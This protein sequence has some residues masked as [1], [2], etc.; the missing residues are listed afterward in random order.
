MND[1]DLLDDQIC[2]DGDAHDRLSRVHGPGELHATLLALLLPAGSRRALQAWREETGSAAPLDAL[3]EDVRNLSGAA[4]LPW[5]DRLLARM[6][7]QPIEARQRLLQSTRRVIGARGATRPL[8]RLHWLV[9][10]RRLGKT[11]RLSARP[12]SGTDLSQWLESDVRFIATYTAYLARMVRA[13]PSEA[14]EG[15]G[16]AW[17][18]DVMLTWEPP[19]SQPPFVRTSSEL[20]LQAL[21]SLQTLSWMQRPIVVRSWVAAALKHAAQGRMADQTADALRL[22]CALL[23]APEPPDLARHYIALAAER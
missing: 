6:A 4:R 11:P 19:E 14:I 9:M 21:D 18:V 12:E 17:Y 8:D 5:F 15:S 22:S 10:R 23:D 2:D 3:R 7:D 13:D 1:T 16:L 20:M